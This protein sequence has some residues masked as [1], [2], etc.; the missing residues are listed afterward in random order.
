[1]SVDAKVSGLKVVVGLGITGL[2]VVQ[3]LLN[4]GYQVAVTDSRAT[5]PNADELPSTVKVSFG[6]LDAVLLLSADEIIISP[7]LSRELPEIQAAVRAG[8][9]VVGDIH[10]LGREVQRMDTPVP[11]VAITGS[12]AKS[13]VTTLV[14]NMAA[15]AGI[16]VAV[17][18]NLGRP[19]L[20]LL[21]D[22]PELIVLEVSSFQLESTTQLSPAVATVLNMSPDHLDRHHDMAGY[23]T[24]KHRVFQGAKAIVVNRDDALT[25]PQSAGHLPTGS[26]GLHAPEDNQ[27]GLVRD[28]SSGDTWIARGAERLV[29]SRELHI[30]GQ[31]NLLNAQA[32]LALGE[33]VNVPLPAMLAALK[34]FKGL[35]HR[36]EYIANVAG[37]DYF[38]DSKGTNV[39]STLA[40]IYG[41]GESYAQGES[42][43]KLHVILGGEGKGQDFSPLVDALQTYAVSVLLIGRDAKVIGQALPEEVTRH[44]CDTLDA[45]VTQAS[46]DA[47]QGDVVLLSPACASFDQFKSYVDR[48][49]QF[50]KLV[51]AIA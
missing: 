34:A 24:A 7:G 20:S 44:D 37:V 51:S 15:E 27:Y 32:A 43:Q 10:L 36:C 14:A 38:N 25:Q 49:E 33:L 12:N 47:A 26:F 30:K 35:P 5:P 2:S 16:K 28:A 8:I 19:A 22:E 18:G 29:S 13:T 1:M 4:K 11:I 31:H 3:F 42:T 21:A 17:G 41:L 45:A 48:G 9:P 39:G 6:Q 50:V 46:R 40:A 23:H